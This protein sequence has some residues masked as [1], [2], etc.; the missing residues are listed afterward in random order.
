MK[1]TMISLL[2]ATLVCGCSCK[3]AFGQTPG[4]PFGTAKTKAVELTVTGMTC[5]G[6]ADHVSQALSKHDGIL[7]SD[8]HFASNSTSV[9]YDPAKTNETEIIQTIASA[10]Y[11]AESHGTQAKELEGKDAKANTKSNGLLSFY[12][13]PLVCAAVP[14]IGCGSRAK[15]VLSDFENSPAIEEAWLNRS[16]TVIAVVWKIGTDQKNQQLIASTI[17]NRHQLNAT[18]LLMDEYALNNESFQKK[19]NWL[20]GLDINKLSKEE[21]SIMADRLLKSIKEKTKLNSLNEQKLRDKIN[22]SFYDLFVNYQ[23]LSE[24]SDPQVYKA[25]LADIISFGDGL[26]GPNNMPSLETLWS[27]CSSDKKDCNHEGCKGA[28]CSQPNTTTTTPSCCA[29]KKTN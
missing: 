23:S 3:T 26:L 25:K 4:K 1:T 21:A 27:V 29:P 11:K 10:G 12:Q 18:Q 5:Q 15:P 6:C 14:S 9:T 7:K 17:F 16:G 20:R 24:L 22:T 13:V 8:I 2:V 19:E 28:T